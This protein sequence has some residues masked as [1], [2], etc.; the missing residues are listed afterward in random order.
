LLDKDLET[1]LGEAHVEP[2]EGNTVAASYGLA[3][4]FPDRFVD[5]QQA[6]MRAIARHAKYSG[7]TDGS[8]KAALKDVKPDE[9]YLF[10]I[11]RS[12]RGFAM[13]DAP[14]SVINGDN[15]L[16]LS[17]QTVIEIDAPAG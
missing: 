11:I 15:L 14:V 1:I 2:V 4:V 5:F 3:V 16:N 12:G 13:W 10:A 7:T 9:Y 6:A 17:P 8:G